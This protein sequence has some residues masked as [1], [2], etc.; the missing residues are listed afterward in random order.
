MPKTVKITK[1]SGE[2]INRE[3]AL[4]QLDTVL[5]TIRN[6]DYVIK[7]EKREKKRTLPSNRLFWLWMACLEKE[8]GTAKEDCHDY[9]CNKFLSRRAVIN[10]SEK[11]VTGGTSKLNTVQ[12]S[13]FLNRIQADAASEFGI[14]LP[15]PEDLYWNEFEAYYN[16]FI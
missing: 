1:Q 10:G 13:D 16:N 6:G 8:T 15:S 4:R 2:I 3:Y 14:T 11:T 9:Y 5:G 7:I 12:F